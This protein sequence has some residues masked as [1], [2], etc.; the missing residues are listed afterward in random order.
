MEILTHFLS[1]K[2][3][4]LIFIRHHRPL[5]TSPKPLR[6]FTGVHSQLTLPNSLQSDTLQALE[7][8]SL[9]AHLA[10]FTSTSTARSVAQRATIPIGSSPE[11]SQKLL[12]Q[13]SAA[14][15]VMNS[16]PPLD[17]SQFQDIAEI[18][19]SAVSGTLLTVGELCSVRRTL[20]A[21]RTVAERLIQ[22]DDGS[23]RI[24]SLLEIIHGC[25]FQSE[26]EQKIGFCIDCNLL[27]IL[28]RA[29]EELEMIRSERKKNM[30]NMEALLKAVSTRVFQGGGIDRPLVTKRRRRF[31]V[32]VRAT[33]RRLVPGGIVLD[34]SSSGATYYM[35]PGEAV[36]L[37][38][39][40]VTLSN[41]EKEE[42]V[43][44]LSM[45]TAEIAE[46]EM[47]IKYVLDCIL[48]IDLAFARA[49]YSQWMNGVCPILTSET[50]PAG[51]LGDTYDQLLVDI[52]GIQHP[53]LLAKRDFPNI[54]EVKR[55]NSFELDGGNGVADK[56]S[57][58]EGHPD[59][60]VPID[61]K[62]KCG[63]RVVV[64]SG[65]NTGG[66]TASM[67][68]LGVASLMSK[69][70]LYLPAKNAPKLP[71]FD[72]VLADIGDHQSLEQSL[73]TFSGH[74]SRICNI[75]ELASE[76]S[77]VL[78]DEI[79]SG[80]DPSEGVAL[81]ASILKYLGDRVNLAVVTTHYADLS[82]LKEKD[83]RFENAAMEFC[84]KTLQPTYQVLWGSTGDSNALSIAKSI[85]F[86][87]N[88]IERA[89]KWLDKLRPEMQQERRGLLYESL[90][91]ERGRLKAEAEK[92]ASLHADT[93]EIY[94]ELN[95]FL[96]FCTMDS[97]I[98]LRDEAE[99]LDKRVEALMAKETQQARQEVNA[100]KSEIQTVMQ[101]FDNLLRITIPEQ[102]NT[103]IR[104]SEDRIA[105]IVEVH[106][107]PASG[108]PGS[109]AN[110][111]SYTPQLGERVLVKSLGDKIAT[112][113]Q[114]P[115]DDDA[116]LVQYGKIKVRVNKTEIR[117]T[118][119]AKKSSTSNL[120][121]QV[122]KQ[123]QQIDSESQIEK[124]KEGYSAR[125]QTSRNTVDLRGMRVEAAARH[126]TA[127]ISDR[128]AQSVIFVVHGTG[129]GAVKK[130][131]LEILG[132]HPRVT[133]YE[134]ESPTN[135]GCTVAYIKVSNHKKCISEGNQLHRIRLMIWRSIR[136]IGMEVAS[137]NVQTY[138]D[139]EKALA[140]LLDAFGSLFSLEQI[141]SAY[142][143]AG[144]DPNLA[145]QL[146]YD[147]QGASS[148]AASVYCEPIKEEVD[149]NA[150]ATSNSAAVRISSHADQKIRAPKKKGR[151][152]SAGSVSSFLGKDYVVK[153]RPV[154]N[155]SSVA[156]KPL[157][158]DANEWLVPDDGEQ[159]VK[160]S[161][162]V[163]G[164]MQENMVEF[165]FNMLGNGS[166]ME[167]EVIRDVLDECGYDMQAGMEKLINLSD[168]TAE[169]NDK[170]LREATEKLSKA[171]LNNEGPR[172]GLNQHP[173]CSES[174]SAWQKRND[175]QKE[176]LAALFTAERDEEEPP[177][178][179]VRHP[180]RAVSSSEVV[181]QPLREVMVSKAIEARALAAVDNAKS[182]AAEVEDE[183][184][185]LRRIVVESRATMKEYFRSSIEAF[186][187]EEYEKAERL[188]EKGKFFSMKAQQADDE[189]NSKLFETKYAET[190]D[191]VPLNLHEHDPKE[192]IRFLKL[193]LSNLSGIS[194][195]FALLI[196]LLKCVQLPHYQSCFLFF[197]ASAIKYLKI[198]VETNEEDTSKGKRKR[199][200]KKFLERESLG[201]TEDEGRPG[202]IMVQVDNLDRSKLSFYEQN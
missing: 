77:L 164:S 199:T 19:D 61:I 67:K 201:Y 31:C 99:E 187:K 88:I 42:E 56:G 96:S 149:G 86:D 142:C 122:K 76:Q 26:L 93:M 78:I 195:A 192:A 33:H 179:I 144:R 85:G 159:N 119:G 130:R 150:S 83:A 134:P 175:L 55:E 69:A 41:S 82:L 174:D 118:R 102:Y 183:Y 141:A 191:Q 157:K 116:I 112:V 92:S 158:L 106:S 132:K 193:H 155:G 146:L 89:Q 148:S 24:G 123:V 104:K 137:C 45:L 153:S 94:N 49:G 36:E 194:C 125:V 190:E 156:M 181:C 135:W 177:R 147:S 200:V 170:R 121:S 98:K 115:G 66:K 84:L 35:E 53:L 73:S 139:E 22:I 178:R 161:R 133:K 176:V 44:I 27:V 167:R 30:E 75:L 151:A 97:P 13:T 46:S 3:S 131:T 72:L 23:D 7:W 120:M 140:V 71:W 189:S 124:P 32:G 165:L 113:V 136:K 38:N 107:P 52:E 202:I 20:I 40:E 43:A 68:T 90:V 57:I 171:S 10:R 105:S 48:A 91:E 114:A 173:N 18:V 64:I 198:V 2:A 128:E 100:V 154:V 39:S 110:R 126:L 87:I 108:L 145:G 163:N 180:R 58:L 81:S 51:Y 15:S 196:S 184:Q 60:P 74:I 29:S 5:K 80:T 111:R 172:Q 62:V 6:S 70:G 160:Q 37:N 138:D 168:I 95:F 186:T 127:A 129:T 17:L 63:T 4:H 11:E 182:E 12:D 47:G 166:K 169:R 79:C 28:D 50:C 34:I 16:G 14:I 65:P 59:F 25:D 54:L 162:S 1:T 117:A 101:D 21:A 152:V 103:L 8:D 143:K 109:E 9:C 188:M 185:R 197:L